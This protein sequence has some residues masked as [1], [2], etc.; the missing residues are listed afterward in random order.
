MTATPT[1]RAPEIVEA[2]APR[3]RNAAEARVWAQLEAARRVVEKNTP[4]PLPVDMSFRF[5]PP[6]GCR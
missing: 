2:L 6:G 5:H 3:P 1:P 4:K